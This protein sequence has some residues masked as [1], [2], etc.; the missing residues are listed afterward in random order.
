MKNCFFS[1]GG[2]LYEY[3]FSNVARNIAGNVALY[4]VLLQIHVNTVHYETNN[5]TYLVML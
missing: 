4:W 5:L 3:L 2:S 1:I